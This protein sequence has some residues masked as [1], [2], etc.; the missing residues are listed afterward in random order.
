MSGRTHQK[1]ASP[2]RSIQSAIRTPGKAPADQVI[3]ELRQ[4]GTLTRAELARRTGLAR[5]TI[6]ETVAELLGSGIVVTSE[7]VRRSRGQ[8][9]PGIGLSLDPRAGAWIGIDFGMS[10]V[11]AVLVDVSHTIL[12]TQELAVGVDYSFDRGIDAARDVTTGVL[13]TA[14][15]PMSRVVAIGAAVPGPVDI[16]SGEV[17]GT[18]MIPSWTGRSVSGALSDRLGREVL[19][20]NDSNCAALAEHAWGAGRDLGDIA[21]L[22]LHSGTGGALIVGGELVRG[23]EGT[24]GEFGHMTLDPAGPLCRCGGRGCLETY[25]GVAA[26]LGQLKPRHG[27]DLSVAGLLALVAAHDPASLRVAAELGDVVGRAAALISN[28]A[29]PDAFVIGGALA[30]LGPPLL[31]P[32]RQSFSRNSLAGRQGKAP[33]ARVLAGELGRHASALGAVALLMTDLGLAANGWTMHD[34]SLA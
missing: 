18:S 4:R 27:D 13:E 7:R 26:V 22:K 6:S 16:R 2:S 17:L 1:G 30:A 10:H 12:A 34:R 3:L 8:G 5:S 11:R 9:R 23:R 20:D 31:E 33:R 21:Y 28:V 15:V 32:L 29:A 24:A 19:V 14:R 25:A